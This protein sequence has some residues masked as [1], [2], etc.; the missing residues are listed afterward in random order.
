M[1]LN[2]LNANADTQLEIIKP[3]MKIQQIGI[4]TVYEKEHRNKLLED[5]LVLGGN[6]KDVINLPFE[7]FKSKYY[8]VMSPLLQIAENMGFEYWNFNKPKNISNKF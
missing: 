3:F 7:N 2:S 1:E 4:K 8:N 5:Y 6:I